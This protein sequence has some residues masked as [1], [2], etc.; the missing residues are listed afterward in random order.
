MGT[1]DDWVVK[2]KRL[3]E[4]SLAGKR[5]LIRE[6][7]NVPIKDGLVTSNARIRSAMPTIQHCIQEKA[8]V[9][10]MSH[11]G[12]PAA[13]T[14]DAELS[15]RPVAK[16]LSAMLG[17]QVDLISDWRRHLEV[18]PGDVVLI[19]NVRFE[20]GEAANES[21][22]GRAYAQLC[23][24]FVM[25]AFATAHRAQAS[26]HAVAVFADEACAGPLLSS[27]LDA[28][29]RVLENPERPLVTIVG[30]SK[31][32]AKLNTLQ[33]LADISDTIVVGGGIANTFL[34][35]AGKPIGRSLAEPELVDIAQSIIARSAVFDHVDVMTGAELN[36]KATARLCLTDS[37]EEDDVIGDIGPESA[38]RIAALVH[39]AGT[40][41]WNGPV[42][43]F[44]IDQFGE[45]T[46]VVAEAIAQSTAFSIVG[47]GDTIAAIEKY[48]VAEEI[49]YISTGGGA[50]LEVLEGRSLPALEALELSA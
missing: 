49:S 8:A 1:R 15:L 19:E 23:D 16:E 13:E 7:L 21:D 27:E 33:S 47:G 37:V 44:E 6:D 28:L 4:F 38:R 24:I 22:L 48:E 45:G 29:G 35:A 11:L 3:G 39:N 41:I 30:G 20:K 26:T 31:V 40:V 2:F 46:R 42:G 14:F 50:F 17:I 18:Q 5:V 36:N 9:I 43:V 32:S 10:I 12:R 25:D 34:L